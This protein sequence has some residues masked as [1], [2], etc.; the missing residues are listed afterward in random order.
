[1]NK[2]DF[3]QMLT[4]MLVGGVQVGFGVIAGHMISR[5]RLPKRRGL[6][7]RSGSDHFQ[8][9][10]SKIGSIADKQR[11]ENESE[12]PGMSYESARKNMPRVEDER[13]AT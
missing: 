9:I 3:I 8:G 5:P 10:V 7:E 11:K 13:F 6:R 12:T 4:A 2:V 1:M